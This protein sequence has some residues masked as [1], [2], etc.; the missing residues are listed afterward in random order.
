MSAIGTGY[1]LS[2]A[3]FS[4]EGRIF[5]LEYALKAVENSGTAIALKCKDGVVFAVE[6]I[7]YSKLYEKG[8]N[9]RIFHVTNTIGLAMAG[10]IADARA[11]V[12]IARVE[13]NNY[14]D[15]YGCQIPVKYLVERVSLYMHAYTLYSAVR[16][17]GTSVLISAYENDK[18]FLYMI[19]PSGIYYGYNC[20]AIGKGTTQT[21]TEMEKIKTQEMTC[22]ELVKHA[23]K[24]IHT[25]HDDTKDKPFEL[26]MSWVGEV[27]KGKHEN[28]P[29]D[30][31]D[32]IEVEVKK[33]IENA[34]SD[35]EM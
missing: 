4:P 24:I 31:I 11:I 1:D 7:V 27:T 35:E 22:N 10:L 26:E 20:V 14:H 19:E 16:P 2:A 28:V 15:M 3:Q 34:D 32:K 23:A 33:E 29:Q 17:F 12:E 8:V 5:Q 30:L 13:A 25:I 18:P 21:K 6:K 9:R